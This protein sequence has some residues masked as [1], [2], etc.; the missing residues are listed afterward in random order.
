MG[1]MIELQEGQG[2]Y[3]TADVEAMILAH[4]NTA[5]A[6]A[7]KDRIIRQA[8]SVINGLE[9]ALPGVLQGKVDL[10]ALAPKILGGSINSVFPPDLMANLETLANTIMEYN[11]K[12]NVVTV[13]HAPQK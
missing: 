6:D 9:K 8:T 11:A 4:N 5:E 2:V 10:M 1:Q 3:N 12:H 7:E 13:L